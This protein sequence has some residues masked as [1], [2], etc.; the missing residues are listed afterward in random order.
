MTRRVA[1]I[2]AANQGW[3]PLSRGRASAVGIESTDASHPTTSVPSI[4]TER[5]LLHANTPII[6]FSDKKHISE[7]QAP[8]KANSLLS[9]SSPLQAW[10][11]SFSTS[12]YLGLMELDRSVFGVNPIRQ[13]LIRRAIDYELSWLAQGTESSKNLGQV[14]GSTVKRLT[15]KGRG[16]ARHGTFRANQMRGGYAAHGP[17]PHIRTLDIPAKVYQ[18]GLRSALSVKYLQDQLL[19]VDSLQLDSPSKVDL[20]E[21]LQALNISGKSCFFLVGSDQP[22]TNLIHAADMFESVRLDD[23]SKERALMV[24]NVRHVT[25]HPLMVNEYVVVDKAAVEHFRKDWQLRVKTWFDQPGRKNRRRQA[26]VQKA[27][28]IAPRPIDGL[29]KPAVRGQTIKYNSKLRSGRGFSLIELKQAGIRR[30]EARTIGIA[31]DHRRKNRSEEGLA[32]N[33]ERLKAYKSRLIVFPKK[34]KRSTEVTSAT[35]LAGPIIPIV[36]VAPVVAFGKLPAGEQ[37][38]YAF[39]KLRVS[40]TDLRMKGKRD[41]KAKAAEEESEKSG[42][43]KESE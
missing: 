24:A 36:Q 26:R 4:S 5:G 22:S 35:Q 15:Q 41:A 20:F 18:A 17:R 3:L 7:V 6:S 10:L 30:K 38:A 16:A 25:V 39:K 1:R 12:N 29:L 28:A 32:M 31:V 2:I 11:Q 40:A 43:K 27:A 14:R 9:S 13:D 19:V 23:G 34:G 42:K 33:V 21:R 37:K 8:K